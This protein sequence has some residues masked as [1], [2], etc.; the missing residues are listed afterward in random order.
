VTPPLPLLSLLILVESWADWSASGTAYGYVVP[1]QRDFLMAVATAD[2]RWVHL[3]A[4]YDYE[5]LH[6]GSLLLGVNA[7]VGERLRLEV[8]GMVGTVFGDTAGVAPALRV[9]LTWWKLDLSTENEY[10]VDVREV[11]ASFFYSWSELGLSPLPW[12]RLGVVA[13]RTRAITSPLD[14]QRGVLVGVRPLPAQAL[15][16]TLYQLNLGWAAPT[17]IAALGAGY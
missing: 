9:T 10:V 6:T 1:D 5:G 16:L 17:F 11:G 4:R 13:Q 14:I 12:L 8:T 2:L 15:T 7:G 3:E